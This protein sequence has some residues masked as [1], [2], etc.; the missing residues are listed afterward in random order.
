VAGVR[1]AADA[2]R[3][4]A[5]ETGTLDR[6]VFFHEGWVPYDERGSW[7]AAAD[8]GVSTHKQHIETEFSF[9]TRLLDYLWCGLPV[10]STGGDDLAEHVAAHGAGIAV[11]A[12]DL[13]ALAEAV[14]RAARDR[15]WRTTAGAAS[16]ALADSFRWTRVVAPLAEFCATP[17][18]A[19][20]LLLDR[21]DRLQ[22]G[23]GG[24]VT[25]GLVDRLRAAWREGGAGQLRRRLLHR[26][27]GL[28][29][30]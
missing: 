15:S 18:R 14:D 28:T 4:A 13:T 20:D 25:P 27:A 30:R 22:V 21:V 10:I 8:V 5:A 23:V 17:T 6:A 19:P 24:P 16:G 3:E 29:R 7:L 1:T 11:P 2:A 9:R 26:L 12:G